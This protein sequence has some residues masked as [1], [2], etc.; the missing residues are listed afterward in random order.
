MVNETFETLF[1]PW[2]PWGGGELK[3]WLF[4]PYLLTP[5]W[6]Q[7]L[8]ISF[9]ISTYNSVMCYP[10]IMWLCSRDAHIYVDWK[11]ITAAGQPQYKI[12]KNCKVYGTPYDCMSVMHYRDW[13]FQQGGPTMLPRRSSCDLK[14]GNYRLT[15]SDIDLL[16]K[17]YPCKTGLSLF[18]S[19]SNNF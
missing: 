17:M 4:N 9:G 18:T 11:Y 8:Q 15:Q 14:S 16:N 1:S 5:H 6:M 2:C 3:F 7:T 10:Y 13:G 12:C 19:F